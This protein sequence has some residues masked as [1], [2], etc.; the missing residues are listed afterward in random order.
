MGHYIFKWYQKCE[1]SAEL[2][3]TQVVYVYNCEQFRFLCRR[4]CASH[5][6]VARS[7]V[8]SAASCLPKLLLHFIAGEAARWQSDPFTSNIFS[9]YSW[10]QNM[11]M[12]SNYYNTLSPL[13]ATILDDCHST[14]FTSTM[15]IIHILTGFTVFTCLVPCWEPSTWIFRFC[16]DFVPTGLTK[17]PPQ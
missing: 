6:K 14:T 17:P 12:S 3:V 9:K 10:V 15:T 5:Y 13:T 7:S 1:P 16:W 4:G 11:Q 2:L 8:S